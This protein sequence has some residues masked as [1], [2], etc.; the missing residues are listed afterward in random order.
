[1]VGLWGH[2]ALVY[3]APLGWSATLTRQQ[4]RD[5]LWLFRGHLCLYLSF[6]VLHLDMH[7]INSCRSEVSQEERNLGCAVK[8]QGATSVLH[9]SRA[10]KLSS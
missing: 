2:K 6:S 10:V 3:A 4:P 1:M 7:S 5:G 9:G 8:E